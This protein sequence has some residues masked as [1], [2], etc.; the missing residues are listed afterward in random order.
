MRENALESVERR[1][2]T[3]SPCPR[4]HQIRR[5]S[6]MEERV[7]PSSIDW[8]EVLWA[9]SLLLW[10][11]CERRNIRSRTRGVIICVLSSAGIYWTYSSERN[12]IWLPN[13]NLWFR[14]HFAGCLRISFCFG[15]IASVVTWNDS[16]Y[17]VRFVSRRQLYRLSTNIDKK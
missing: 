12:Q 1:I 9:I 5:T 13:S 3:M 7:V 4:A 15:R 2:A 10:G 8:R 11:P 14:R 17:R 16:S 6:P